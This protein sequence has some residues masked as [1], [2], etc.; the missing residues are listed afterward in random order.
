MGLPARG[1]LLVG[2]LF[3]AIG[4]VIIL[5]GTKMLPVNP[6]SVHAPYWVLTA[7]GASFALGGLVVC[8]MAW[9]HFAADRNWL[10][11]T[12][13]YPNEPAL[14]DY[15]W[16]PDG[17]EVSSWK[18]AGRAV[19]LAI[20]VTIFLSIFNWWAFW[21]D[22]GWDIRALVIIFD[23]VAL[24]LWWHAGRQIGSAL[25]FGRSRIAF[26][27]FPYRLN[28]PVIIRWQPGE[29][30]SQVNKGTFTLRCVEEWI[31]SSGSGKYRTVTLVHEELWSAKWVLDQPRKLQLKDAVELRYELP[32]DARPTR[33]SGERPMFW[34]LEVQLDLPGLN[35]KESYLVPIY[36]AS[37]ASR[38]ASPALSPVAAAA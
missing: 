23:C 2:S 18:G 31:E 36:G 28:E 33:L 19:G 7:A 26:P 37:T 6:A 38:D 15:P 14:A 21:S 8:G 11:A 12:R 13:Q 35:F 17:F 24:A 1:K 25:K 5:V 16:H 3:V 22:G 20:G 34:E 29:G 27:H 30:V 9:R 32:P 4:T 10:Y